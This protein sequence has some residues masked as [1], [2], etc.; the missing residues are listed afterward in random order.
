MRG[1]LIEKFNSSDTNFNLVDLIKEKLIDHSKIVS[2]E[3]LNQKII[4]GKVNIK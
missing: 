3:I 2:E 4:F 1:Y